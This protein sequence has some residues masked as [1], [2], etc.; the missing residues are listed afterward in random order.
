MIRPRR[1][2]KVCMAYDIGDGK[3]KKKKKTPPEENTIIKGKPIG[4]WKKSSSEEKKPIVDW[5]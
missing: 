1:L 2:I 3:L 5:K 4:D